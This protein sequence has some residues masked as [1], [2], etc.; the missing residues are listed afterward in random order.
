MGGIESRI[1]I[2]IF[3][4]ERIKSHLIFFFCQNI[5]K[6][7]EEKKNRGKK[8]KRRKKK[9][10]EKKKKKKKGNPPSFKPGKYALPIALRKTLQQTFRMLCYISSSV[11]EFTHT[12]GQ[13]L[14]VTYNSGF[15]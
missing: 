7:R 9:W 12:D 8:H 5:T 4:I 3:F 15:C 6:I 2:N 14:V 10:E 11:Y 1:T 13:T